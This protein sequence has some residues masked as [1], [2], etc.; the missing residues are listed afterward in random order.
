LLNL[1]IAVAGFALC[2]LLDRII[3]GLIIR[4][5]IRQGDSRVAEFRAYLVGLDGHI[6]GYEPIICTGDAEAIAIAHRLI[7]GGHAVEV[8][9]GP[10][11]VSRFQR[12]PEP[13]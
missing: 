5:S 9:S 6:I 12:E 2:P 3:L 1:K 7:D 4:F 13:R 10:R 11:L 8:W